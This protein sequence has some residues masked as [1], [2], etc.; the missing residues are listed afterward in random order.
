M[1]TSFN[2]E[3]D[4][5]PQNR[6]KIN[7]SQGTVARVSWEDLGGHP[8]TGLYQGSEMGLIRLSEGN[9]IL[10]EAPGLTPTLAIKFLRDGMESVN[11]L[12]NTNFEPSSSWNFF[13]Q[14]FLSH[15]P[16]FTDECAQDSIEAKFAE[17]TRRVGSVGLAEFA[18][19]NTDGSR[20]ADDDM[21]F[22]FEITFV[23]N[24]ALAGQLGWTDERQ[25]DE[26][27]EEVLFYD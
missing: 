18:R 24:Q 5:L 8:Y 9:F 16:L 11:H 2:L 1:G 6:P 22:P 3:A 25:F 13:A 15:I 23:P 4:E 27:G 7:H 21:E 19:F 26:N 20:I 14:D 12:A 10:P 17:T